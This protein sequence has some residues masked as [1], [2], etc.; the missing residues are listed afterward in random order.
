VTTPVRLKLGTRRSALAL[1]QS[2]L[3]ADLLK[4]RHH[5]LQVDLV[6]IVSTGDKA[7]DIAFG[8]VGSVGM[9]VKELENALLSGM[10][11]FAVHSLKD[12]PVE[13]TPGLVL[14]AVPERGT[15]YDVLITR[16][17]DILDDLPDGAR[18]GTGSLR[19]Q[20]Q[21][22]AYRD[23]LKMVDI[24]GNIDTR[25]NR[26]DSGRYDG[27]VLAAAGIERL[28]LQERVAEIF[29]PD[30]MLPAVG[31]GCLALQA[32]ADDAKTAA[33]LAAIDDSGS[34]HAA[35]AERALLAGLGGGCHAPIAAL[36]HLEGRK[37]RLTGLVGTADGQTILREEE[38]GSAVSAATVGRK[39]A[40]RLLK[41]GADEILDP[42]KKG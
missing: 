11:D 40:D 29:T 10:V 16:E 19:R 42:F 13:E 6:H 5:G 30:V 3:V 34:R 2:Q 21:M 26:L 1:A 38:E 7:E 41:M 20:A 18:I 8:S 4:A 37:I 31:Q 35:V 33:L 32:R 17:G 15:P 14:C 24:R 27:I 12:L 28:G 22:L 25:I 39:L 9:F 23:D 36:A